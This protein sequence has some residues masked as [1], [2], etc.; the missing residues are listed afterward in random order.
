MA[1]GRRKRF[2]SGTL[3]TSVADLVTAGTAPTDGSAKASFHFTVANK[4]GTAANVTLAVANNASTVLA[5][6]LHTF[7]IPAYDA[8]VH[9]ETVDLL[10]GEKLVGFAGT[11]SALD[12]NV[13]GV[14]ASDS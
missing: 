11:A 10:G 5:Y 2:Y 12:L 9:S 13:M 6:L 1:I 4:T 14:E 8:Y 7:P 3:G